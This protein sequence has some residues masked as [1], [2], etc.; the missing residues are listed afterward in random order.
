MSAGWSAAASSSAASSSA[1]WLSAKCIVDRCITRRERSGRWEV[2]PAL[3]RCNRATRRLASS[4]AFQVTAPTTPVG[5]S[6][7]SAWNCTTA[8]RVGS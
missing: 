3:A 6:P 8:C 7:R 1:G 4:I 2:G 5:V